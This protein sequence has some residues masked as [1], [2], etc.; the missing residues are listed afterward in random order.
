MIFIRFGLI[1]LILHCLGAWLLWRVQ[2]GA[3]GGVIDIGFRDRCVALFWSP[4][5]GWFLLY[6][7]LCWAW[8]AMRRERRA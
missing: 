2:S 6:G 4:L 5:L 7:L 1:L 3:K 8:D